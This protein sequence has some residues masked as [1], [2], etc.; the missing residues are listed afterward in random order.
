[1]SRSNFLFL[2]ILNRWAVKYILP[3][4]NSEKLILKHL[5]SRVSIDSLHAQSASLA[6]LAQHNL[7]SSCGR[8]YSRDR[9]LHAKSLSSI[10]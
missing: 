9:E 1:M 10:F 7:L 6:R 4:E 5:K 8:R 2:Q 3:K